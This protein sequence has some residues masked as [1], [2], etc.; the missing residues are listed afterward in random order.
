MSVF[1]ITQVVTRPYISPPSSDLYTG[2]VSPDVIPDGIEREIV[3]S[4]PER[5]RAVPG[6]PSE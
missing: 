5:S 3:A 1:E 4:P 6:D 2:R